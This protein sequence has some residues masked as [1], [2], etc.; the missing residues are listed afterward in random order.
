MNK[1]ISVA[2]ILLKKNREKI[3]C[4]TAYTFPVAKIL[5]D[6]C[7]IIL[8]GDSLGMTIYGFQDTVDVTLEMMINHGKAVVKAVK[9]SFVVV[10][11]PYGTYEESQE[12]ALES[13]KKVMQETGC[14]AI[15]IETSREMTETVKFLVANKISVMAHIGLLPQSVRKIGGYKYQGRDEKSAEEIL[16][17]AKM[18][19]SAGAFSIVIEA[20]PSILADKISA[21]VK[22]PTIGI[23]ASQNCDGQ[24][25]VIDDLLGLNQEFKPRFVTRYANLADEIKSAVKKFSS[26]VK[27]KKFPAK[28]NLL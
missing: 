25:L 22:I 13:A 4:L 15:K 5:D 6:Y 9:K 20:V 11:L 8:V 10:D 27:E 19:E 16:E 23:G 26:E 12:Q 3:I 17:T 18:L 14:D 21:A 2:D 7:D 28:E 1:R 24:V